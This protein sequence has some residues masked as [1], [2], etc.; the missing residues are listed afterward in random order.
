MI[1]RETAARIWKCHDEIEKGTELLD[2]M[3][4]EMKGGE[5]PKFFDSFGRPRGLSLGVPI[6]NDGQRLMD[7]RPKLALSVIRAHIAYKHKE[8]VEA[9]ESARIELDN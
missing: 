4:D 2:K 6:G 5:Q 3:Q 9:C 1:S 7:I 8:L